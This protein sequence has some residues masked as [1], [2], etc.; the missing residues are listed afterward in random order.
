MIQL[1]RDSW[2]AVLYVCVTSP[3][4]LWPLLLALIGSIALTQ[5]VKKLAIPPDWSDLATARC[6]QLVAL[7][8]GMAITAILMPTRVVMVAGFVIGL[9]SPFVYYIGVRIVGLKWPVTREWL[10]QTPSSRVTGAIGD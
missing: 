9:M 4:A 1:I 3:A 8:S 2:D 5:V 6:C 10:S 7:L